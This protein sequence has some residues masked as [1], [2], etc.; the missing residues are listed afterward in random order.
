MEIREDGTVRAPG[1]AGTTKEGGNTDR[2]WT[3]GGSN[4]RKGTN[5][6]E[7]QERRIGRPIQDEGR[8]AEGGAKPKEDTPG[9]QCAHRWRVGRGTNLED[10]A[11]TRKVVEG[12][13]KF[14]TSCD[15]VRSDA[16]P[17]IERTVRRS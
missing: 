2:E 17:L 9:V 10:L 4:R 3:N 16:D 5:A 1:G 15:C 12:A 13:A 8:S 11:A 7:A 6:G 14:Q